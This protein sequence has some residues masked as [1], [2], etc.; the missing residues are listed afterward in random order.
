MMVSLD[1]DQQ[2]RHIYVIDWEE[3]KTGIPAVELGKFCAEMHLLTRFDEI[4]KEPASKVLSNFLDTYARI[5]RQ[6][7]CLAKDTL[8]RLGGHL[9]VWTPRLPWGDKH[10]TRNVVKEGV[11]FLVGCHKDDFVAHSPVRSLLA[12]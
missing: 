6:D 7:Q 1:D 9:V 5:S 12:K 10:S 3:A 2:L 8:G 4:A 11:Q